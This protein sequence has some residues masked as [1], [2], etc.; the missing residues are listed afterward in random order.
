RIAKGDS[1]G[2]SLPIASN[3]GRPDVTFS[4]DQPMASVVADAA[5]RRLDITVLAGQGVPDPGGVFLANVAQ[6]LPGDKGVIWQDT[7]TGND[8][9][10][11][12]RAREAS[13]NMSD[14]LRADGLLWTGIAVGF[15]ALILIAR[16]LIARFFRRRAAK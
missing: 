9:S 14:V 16:G 7:P 2:L 11:I 1:A 6:A 13:R 5:A 4:T 12:Q 15:V 8:P 10:L 3:P